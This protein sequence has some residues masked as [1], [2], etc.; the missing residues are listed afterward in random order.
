MD[1]VTLVDR[2]FQG[3]IITNPLKFEIASATTEFNFE[4]SN[5]LIVYMAII[6]TLI[7][8]VSQSVIYC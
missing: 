8:L 1:T 6:N 5:L 2:D 7:M 4:N 3:K